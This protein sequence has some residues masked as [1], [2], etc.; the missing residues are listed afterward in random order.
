MDFHIC[1]F[2]FVMTSMK[3]VNENEQTNNTQSISHAAGSLDM[4]NKARKFYFPDDVSIGCLDISLYPKTAG[5][6]IPDAG[7]GWVLLPCGADISIS[8][9]IDYRGPDCTGGWWM[10]ISSA[11]PLPDAVKSKLSLSKSYKFNVSSAKG[12]YARSITKSAGEIL[13]SML[14]V[15]NHDYAC[16]NFDL[17]GFTMPSIDVDDWTFT[18]IPF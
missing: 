9:F 11:I 7:G 8:I 15:P 18:V 4:M 1:T 17:T 12:N 16:A 6:S 2:L 14:Y 5:F 3:E 13:N 10:A